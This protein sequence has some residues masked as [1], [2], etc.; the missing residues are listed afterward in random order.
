[1]GMSRRPIRWIARAV[2]RSWLS[3]RLQR[4]D[5]GW[6]IALGLGLLAA[7]PFLMRPGLPRQTDAELHVYRAAQ[8]QAIWRAGV[9]Y[10]RW[11]PDLYLGY[12]YPI[13]NYY[14]PLTYYLANLV[15]LLPG[16]NIVEGVK[17]VFVAALLL[18]AL[19]A[20]GFA[21]RHVGACPATLA[22]ACFVFSPYIVFID[23]HA[24]GD[25]AEHFAICLL[26]GAFYAFDRVVSGVAGRTDFVVSV[27]AVAMLVLSH[28]L[29]GLV[30]SAFL[31]VYWLWAVIARRTRTAGWGGAVFV[32]AAAITAFF[33]LPAIMEWNAVELNVAGFGH[34]DFRRH[35][36]PLGELLA[37]SRI[38]D[39]GATAPRFLFNVGVVQWVLALLVW[40]T[41]FDPPYRRLGVFFAL[42]A[43]TL[44]FLIS[45]Y[46]RFV[47]ENIPGMEYL[48]FPWR[49]LGP[50]AFGLAMC[51]AVG[52]ASVAKWLGRSY[53]PILAILLLV[54]SGSALPLL[55]P[56]IWPA[57]FGGTS[58]RDIIAWEI[59]TLA[60]GTTSTGDFVPRGAAL[61]P[62]RPV[63]T[64]VNSYLDSPHV[65]KVNR[66]TIPDGT[67]VQVLEHGPLHDHFWVSTPKKFILRLYTFY[68]PGWRAYIDGQP[69]A[70]EIAYPEGF[71]TV[72]VPSGEHEVVVRF[73]DTPP[74]LFGWAFSA[75]GVVALA[76]VVVG[77]RTRLGWHRSSAEDRPDARPEVQRCLL[78]LGTATAA[79]AVLKIGVVDRQE[80]WFRYTSPPGQA[81]AAEHSVRVNFGNEVELIGYDLPRQRVRSGEVFEVTL[82]WH[83]LSSPTRNYQSFVHLTRPV[84]T[85][86]GQDD[87][88]N[89]GDLPT[90]RWPLDKYVWDRY[91]IRVLPGTPPGVYTVYV[92]LY[93]L[94]E[95]TRLPVYDADGSAIGDSAPLASLFVDRPRRQPSV[96]ELG[97]AQLTMKVFADQ[98]LSL[99]G[100]TPQGTE[101]TVPGVWLVTLFWRADQD[102]PAALRRDVAL[103]DENGRVVWASSG[104]PGGF[105]FE[106][107]VAGDVVRD[108]IRLELVPQAGFRE[109]WYEFAVAVGGVRG[110]SVADWV[111]LERVY[112]RLSQGG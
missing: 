64:L 10:S 29:L 95:G 39:L 80:T 83:A 92:G 112:V 93:L 100:F 58:P 67:T 42:S 44:F 6:L 7:Q 109:G 78:W 59:Q 111:T 51:A 27:F 98:G 8:I 34:F 13:F 105:P 76:I 48:Q 86:W 47:W 54:V 41:L 15:A 88:L 57:D 24:R 12:G 81:L 73:E 49:L 104:Q 18:G 94:G 28:N 102:H 61:V 37:P 4:I 103:L 99:L 5:W 96:E 21:R 32:L 66:A 23:P 19:G 11:A 89:P 85:I 55:Y 110:S 87:H 53:G 14:A 20:Y 84:V 36:V 68:F 79:F 65:D 72:P 108:P 46:S 97:I 3:H 26:P 45:P 16:V 22:T 1:M 40:G 71:I 62:M 33:W 91:Q 25:L 9:I 70:I 74:R 35:F 101:V 69:A 82:Y 50:L 107:W 17:A 31:G 43:L 52:L 63:E 75:G 56:P 77:R 106:Q 90:T 38:M 2:L 30:G 60:Y